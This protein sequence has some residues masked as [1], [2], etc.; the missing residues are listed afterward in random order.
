MP[1]WSE[2]D[3]SGSAFKTNQTISVINEI[4]VQERITLPKTIKWESR[5]A[6]GWI[7]HV[8]FMLRCHKVDRLNTTDVAL[9]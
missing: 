7:E 2:L 6:L 1:T 4:D 8:V 5:S 3:V 9:T